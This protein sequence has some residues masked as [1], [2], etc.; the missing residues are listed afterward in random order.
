[1]NKYFLKNYY[2]IYR[3]ASYIDIGIVGSENFL[4]IEYNDQNLS[5]IRRLLSEGY[6]IESVNKSSLLSELFKKNLLIDYKA[7]PRLPISD[8]HANFFEFLGIDRADIESMLMKKTLI[9]GAGAAG[10]TIAYLLAQFGY[11]KICVVDDDIV[12]LSDIE[13]TLIYRRGDINK[14]KVIAL[15]DCIHQNFGFYIEV[16]KAA[17]ENTTQLT[18]IIDRGKPDLIVKA[19]DPDLSFRYYLNQVCFLKSIPFIHMSYSFERINIGP[20]FV[21]GLTKSDSDIE[22]NFTKMCGPEYRFL[23]HRK[24]FQDLTAHPS[25][26]FNINILAGIVLKEII[27]YHLNRH[28]YVYSLNK[29]V[30][31]F[32][33][34]MRVLYRSLNN[35]ND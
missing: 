32:P 18:E 25:T 28:Q 20:F 33:L 26:S 21:P 9:F 7:S 34:S 17:P 23:N 6:N 13:K 2:P 29:E 5:T 24:L 30:F 1:M 3:I 15:K 27:F 19:C 12:E 11:R 31:F 4:Q 22:L 10:A 16:F 35:L 14:S 8:R